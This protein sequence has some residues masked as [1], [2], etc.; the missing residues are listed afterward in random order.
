MVLNQRATSRVDLQLINSLMVLFSNFV[1]HFIQLD[2]FAAI[3]A[4]VVHLISSRFFFHP[5][6]TYFMPVYLISSMEYLFYVCSSYIIGWSDILK[7]QIG[8]LSRFI[9]DCNGTPNPKFHFDL[10]LFTW[11]RAS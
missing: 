8:H 9:V 2:S 7:K 10:L 5:W 11:R 6:H 3:S 1:L 4:N